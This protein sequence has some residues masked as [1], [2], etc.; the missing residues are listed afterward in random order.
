MNSNVVYNKWRSCYDTAYVY[1][2]LIID[3]AFNEQKLEFHLKQSWRGKEDDFIV[4]EATAFAV[5][6]CFTCFLSQCWVA[7]TEFKA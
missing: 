3:L 4:G 2:G 5:L 6:L 1:G 7:T